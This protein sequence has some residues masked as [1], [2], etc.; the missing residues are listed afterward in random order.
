MDFRGLMRVIDRG[1][2]ELPGPPEGMSQDLW[3][4]LND[5]W[6]TDPARRPTMAEIEL[7]IRQMQHNM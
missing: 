5:C 4:L 7:Q 1:H 3:R 6:A 2:L